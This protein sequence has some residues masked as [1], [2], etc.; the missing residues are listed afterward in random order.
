MPDFKDESDE[1]VKIPAFLKNK[2][3]KEG[4]C[5][6]PWV[7]P[8][9]IQLRKDR[10]WSPMQYLIAWI[11]SWVE[12]FGIDGVR[13]DIVENVHLNRWKELNDACNN[14]LEK[15]REKHP[16]SPASKWTDKF[17]MT[18]D[19]DMAGIDFKPD[20]A[21]AGFS[22]MVNFYFPKHGDLDA[23]VYT[24]QAYAD[25]V[26]AHSGWHPF[27]YLNNSYHRDADMT[28]MIDCATTFLLT[29]GVAQIFYG[30]ETGRKLSDARFNVDSDQAFR[31]DMDW[32]DTDRDLLTHYQR[33]GTIRRA[34]PAI[35]IGSQKTINQH[36]CVRTLDGD[37][38]FIKLFPIANNPI[39][40]TG[41]FS[42]GETL[43]ELYTGQVA[44]VSD[45][46]IQFPVYQNKVAIITRK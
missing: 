22:S 44:I 29:P 43:V 25:N 31:S 11:S 40:V 2:W 37:T 39:D 28:N 33:L 20:Y 21:D 38:V 46:S 7:N 23:I 14:A 9:A 18:G 12:E 16:E 42:N 1:P 26:Q 15:W 36:T 41:Y 3:K 32:N 8:S 6:E 34:N 35:G 17:Y 5:N 30:D 4:D 13:C 24:W 27:N 45:N 10:K 19:Y